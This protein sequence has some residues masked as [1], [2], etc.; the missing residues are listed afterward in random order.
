MRTLLAEGDCMASETLT[1]GGL[2]RIEWSPVITGVLCALAAHIVLGLFGAAFGFAADPADSR[3][4]GIAAGLWGLAV[5]F[6]ASLVGAYVCCRIIR[7]ADEASSYL[8]GAMVWCIGLIAG[9]LFISGTV[10]TSAMSTATAASGNLRGGVARSE[11]RGETP[12]SQAQSE[13]A[14]RGA[15]AAAGAGG[16]GALL[17]LAGACLGA[18]AARRALTGRGT[19]A[20]HGEGRGFLDRMH[21]GRERGRRR[22]SDYER[23]YREGMARAERSSGIVSSSTTRS[24]DLGP[25]SESLRPGDDPKVHH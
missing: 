6:V 14:Q 20:R 13:D 15:A 2:P 22:E 10:A 8:H 9:A 4:V 1:R 24:P 12:R 16:L 11:L 3:G 19:G 18:A 7:S 25:G 21:L 23:G 5:P 17:G